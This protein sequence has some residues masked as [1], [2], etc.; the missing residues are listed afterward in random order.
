MVKSFSSRPGAEIQI[1][2]CLLAWWYPVWLTGFVIAI[3]SRL[4]S[5]TL[6]LLALSWKRSSSKKRSMLYCP[7]SVGVKQ[8]SWFP[9]SSSTVSLATACVG[10]RTL[11]ISFPFPACAVETLTRTCCPHCHEPVAST[12]GFTT[13]HLEGSLTSILTGLP[14]IL[15]PP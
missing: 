10:P 3:P 8:T 13:Q 15:L 7:V 2:S 5:S 11:P 12:S 14:G 4:S 6:I 1:S 9:S